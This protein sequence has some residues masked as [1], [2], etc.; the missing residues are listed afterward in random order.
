[1]ILVVWVIFILVKNPMIDSNDREYQALYQ[2]VQIS[3]VFYSS[4]N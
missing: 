3:L 2:A 1:M 4:G